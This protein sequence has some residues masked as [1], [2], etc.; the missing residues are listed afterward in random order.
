MIK[1]V[2]LWPPYVWLLILFL[3]PFALVF[4]IALSDYAI[5]IPPYTPTFDFTDPASWGATLR[6]LDFENFQWLVDDK[7]YFTAYMSSLRIAFVSTFLALMIGYPMA[8]AMARAPQQWRGLLMMLVILPFWS[9]FLIRIY[10]WIGILSNEGFLNMVLGWMGIPPLTIM[11]TNTAVYIGIVYA[12]LPFMILPI[13]ASLDRMDPSLLEAAEDLGCTRTSAFWRITVRL[14]LPGIA[15]GCF[16]VFIPVV[17]EYIVPDLL[18]GSNTL[19]IGKVL[20]EEFFNN[21]DWPVA[22]AVAVVL[23]F[24]LVIPIVLF[25]RAAER[26]ERASA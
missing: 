9:S 6:A 3:L 17:G 4:K 5:A 1:R 26:R 16:L 21:R 2:V 11:N 23:L 10:A 20:V 8:Y 24:V 12:Y 15:A 22:S 13:F 14:S 25:Q 19:M 18:G 7:L